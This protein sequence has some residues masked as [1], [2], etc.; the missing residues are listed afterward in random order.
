MEIKDI[1]RLAGGPSAVAN[2]FGIT[3]QAVSQWD[4]IPSNRALAIEKHLGGEVTAAQMR[5]DIFDHS[6]HVSNT[7]S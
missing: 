1:I 2:L 3:S 4:R 7:S 6:I 5:P